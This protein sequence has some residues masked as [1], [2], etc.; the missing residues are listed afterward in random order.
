MKWL[1]WMLFVSFIAGIILAVTD[2]IFTRVFHHPLDT[3]S[4]LVGV[5]VAIVMDLFW[6]YKLT[7]RTYS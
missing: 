7:E 1:L 3:A 6:T 5:G 4:E 2:L